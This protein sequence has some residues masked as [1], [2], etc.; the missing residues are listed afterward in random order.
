[1]SKLENTITGL[2]PGTVLCGLLFKTPTQTLNRDKHLHD[3]MLIEELQN[4]AA[5]RRGIGSQSM[6]TLVTVHL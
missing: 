3:E 1:V 4:T 5:F 2:C 6:L